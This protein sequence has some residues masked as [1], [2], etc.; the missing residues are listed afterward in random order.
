MR[1]LARLIALA[2][3]LAAVSGLYWVDTLRRTTPETAEPAPAAREPDYYFTGF[4]LRSFERAGAP[5]YS[6]QGERMTHYDD[7]D[8][9]TIAAPVLDYRAPEGALWHVTAE[10]GHVGPGGD[11]VD[12][13]REV[14]VDRSAEA[15]SP[16]EFRTSRLTVLTAAGR[17]ETDRPVT[18]TAPT[19]R[20]R[21][22]GMTAW[23]DRDLVE[24][25]SEV[26]TRYEPADA[27]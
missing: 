4:E 6:L 14:V 9:A 7:D 12:L 19:W 20:T 8:T 22:T 27:R 3:L 25:H 5:T 17:A 23:F 2:L 11:R 21:G 10:R 18:G 15:S 24:L 26:T 1:I 13:V 16:M